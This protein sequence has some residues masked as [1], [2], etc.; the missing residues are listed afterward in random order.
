MSVRDPMSRL[1]SF[2]LSESEYQA[3]Q[4]VCD[5]QE[6]RSLSDFVRTTVRWIAHNAEQ[7]QPEFIE[8]SPAAGPLR[9]VAGNGARF[10]EAGSNGREARLASEVL[11]LRRR[12]DALDREIRRLGRLLTKP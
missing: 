2:R 1:I 8:T 3:L 5:A 7:L 10:P 9:P 4:S 11:S 12:T 6:A